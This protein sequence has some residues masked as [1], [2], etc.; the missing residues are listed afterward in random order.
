VVKWISFAERHAVPAAK[1]LIALPSMAARGAK[2]R[3]VTVL[4]AGAGVVT[5]R[6]DLHYVVTEYGVA[7]LWGK[8]VRARAAALIEIAH[9]DVRSDLLNEAKRRHYVL[10]TSH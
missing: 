2:S 10:P 7:Q 3:I 5:S 1:P 4:E 8:S 9:P 6:G